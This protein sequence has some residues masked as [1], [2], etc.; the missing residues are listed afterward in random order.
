MKFFYVLIAILHLSTDA[1][2]WTSRQ[3]PDVK[4]RN[5][6]KTEV[7][8]RP[9]RS[10]SPRSKVVVNVEADRTATLAGPCRC[11]SMSS[12]RL[13]PHGPQEPPSL[14]LRP[15]RIKCNCGLLQTLHNVL[16]AQVKFNEEIRHYS[17]SG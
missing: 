8:F 4:T 9:D 10:Q 15:F 11:R 1:M 17:K 3:L 6:C 16:H 14:P 2:N 13:A 5:R 7:R 12:G